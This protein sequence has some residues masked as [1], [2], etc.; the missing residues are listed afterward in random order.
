MAAFCPEGSQWARAWAE[1]WLLRQLRERDPG[2]VT[3]STGGHGSESDGCEKAAQQQAGGVRE[4]SPAAPTSPESP[5]S[6]AQIPP[7]AASAQSQ[8]RGGSQG[9]NKVKC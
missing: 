2:T 7:E 8:G 4:E 1:R 3:T 5:A 6:L 9:S